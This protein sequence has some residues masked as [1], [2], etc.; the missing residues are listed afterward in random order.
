[1]DID[2]LGEKIVEQLVDNGLIQ[3]VADLYRL[4]VDD[5]LP[6]ERFAE[7][8][9]QNIIQ[10]I[11]NSK[12]PPLARFI[13]AL[14]IRYV[15]EATA[16][17]LAQHFQRLEAL[18]QASEEELTQIE[19]I[20]PQVARSI[21]DFFTNPRQQALLAKLRQLGVWP[22]EAGKPAAAPWPAKPLFSPAVWSASPGRRPR[23][24]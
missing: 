17:L 12:Q 5:L 15:G 22:Q 20:G 10:A 7:K 13:Y 3:D 6:L 9:A 23:P 19:G 1:M 8:S 14:G 4:Q 16:N 24:W 18:M 11:Q 2:G 21:R